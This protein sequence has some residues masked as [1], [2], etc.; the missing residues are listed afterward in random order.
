MTR[1]I[2]EKYALLRQL[3][4]VLAARGLVRTW[5]SSATPFSD[6]ERDCRSIRADFQDRAGFASYLRANPV[7][8]ETVG[9]LLA[10]LA[11]T[12]NTRWQDVPAVQRPLA[13]PGSRLARWLP[14][15]LII[16]GPLGRV[17]RDAD[18]PLNAVLRSRHQSLPALAQARDLFNDD[19]F[20]LVRNGFGHW[21]FAWRET[22]NGPV[23]EIIDWKT[24]A[25]TTNVTLLEAEALHVASFS[26]IEALD[27]EV[28]ARANPQRPGAST[29]R[30]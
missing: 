14:T 17:L 23:I 18:S 28:F 12:A 1:G 7:I 29:D 20:R 24:G 3:L 9:T 5:A 16:D 10:H 13:R 26:V 21:S 11:I 27:R 4:A 25:I 30:V 8:Q 19:F 15:F 6:L 2:D 22:S